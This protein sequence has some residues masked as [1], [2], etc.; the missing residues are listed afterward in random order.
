MPQREQQL[1]TA[2]PLNFFC[3][4]GAITIEAAAPATDGKT[5][6]PRFSMVAYTGGPMKVS[7]WRYPVIIDLAGLVVPSQSRPI[8]F[9][10]EA[11][12]GIGHSDAIG[13][14]DGKLIAAGV[15]SR[16]TAA[17]REVVA[18]AKNGFPWQASVGAS[19]D[20]FEFVKDSQA[21]IVNG[22]EFSGPV[23]ANHPLRT[24]RRVPGRPDLR[25]ADGRSHDSRP[26]GQGRGQGRPRTG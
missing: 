1:Q 12:S 25:A 10:H 3:E 18:S 23:N 14:H 21:V 2:G 20:H 17:A 8:R 26:G 13:V 11:T 7:G 15:V 19:V 5:P 24:G 9:N 4:P 22:R 6:L 16:D